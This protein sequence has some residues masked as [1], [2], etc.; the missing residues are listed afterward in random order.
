MH[1]YWQ[2]VMTSFEQELLGSRGF[3][4]IP[5]DRLGMVISTNPRLLLPSKSV[6]AYARKQGWST[7]LEWDEEGG[8]WYWHSGDYPPGW[9]KKGKDYKP[10]SIGQGVL[11]NPNPPKRVVRWCLLR[12]TF[13]S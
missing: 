2:A 12:V 13:L 1:G 5:P 6:L 4:L 8:G 10:F 11:P 9:E 3:S 7:I